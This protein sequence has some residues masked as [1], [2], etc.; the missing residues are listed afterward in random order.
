MD[1]EFEKYIAKQS[2]RKI[3]DLL[4]EDYGSGFRIPKMPKTEE[5]YDE[6]LEQAFLSARE[7]SE[8]ES[9]DL[10]DK[11]YYEE[12]FHITEDDEKCGFDYM[13]SNT[14]CGN[15]ENDAY[16]IIKQCFK[17]K[18]NSQEELEAVYNIGFDLFMKDAYVKKEKLRK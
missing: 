18:K 4:D 2:K 11:L 12:G 14:A 3:G 13:L 16:E 1:K 15:C 5:E 17:D 8:Q 6:Y 7:F 9:T 10:I